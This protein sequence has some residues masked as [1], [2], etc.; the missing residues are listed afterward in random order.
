MGRLDVSK[1]DMIN[2]CK[3]SNSHEF[4]KKLTGGYQARIGEGG[5]KLSGGFLKL[6]DFKN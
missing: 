1:S 6:F 3:M 5:V 2:A 4:I